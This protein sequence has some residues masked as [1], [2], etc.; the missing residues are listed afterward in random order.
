MTRATIAVFA[1]VTAS[2][3]S[4]AQ[5]TARALVI[6]DMRRLADVSDPR[7]SR[8]GEWIVFT[9]STV[10][11]VHDRSNGDVWLARW[12]GAAASRA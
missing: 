1:C 9:V 8:D 10:D 2:S 7:M 12:D 4:G 3:S 5:G 11:S 6:S